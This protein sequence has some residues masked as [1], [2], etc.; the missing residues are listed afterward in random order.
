VRSFI[1]I[2]SFFCLSQAQAKNEATEIIRR[3]EQRMR[4]L[5]TQAQM[6]MIV[7]KA[8]F[9]RRMEVRAWTSGNQMAL[10]EI[11]VPA[12]DAG[13]TSLRRADQMWNY[14]PKVDQTVRVP[15]S[16]MLQ[17][18]MGSDFTNDDLMKASSLVRDYTHRIAKRNKKDRTVL[19]ECLPK[20]DAPVVWGRVYYWA[21]TEDSLPVKQAYYDEAGKLVRTLWF[22]KFRKM[23][24]RVIPT[25]V[26]VRPAG[27]SNEYTTVL[28][29][30][31]LYDREL[32][33]SLFD[34]DRIRQ[35]SEQ[36]LKV[37][38]GWYQQRKRTQ[39]ASVR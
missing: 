25:S 39:I 37:S 11:L 9:R 6:E 33:S 34:R 22:D 7:R 31:V 3:G 14:L 4:G 29:K 18:W 8:D 16:L 26:T 36:G 35:Q 13:V 24:D 27:N 15:V 28:Y 17:P 30:R 19:I 23:D 21:R 1:L 10:V 12:K 38:Q 32:P 20:P 2:L 5:S